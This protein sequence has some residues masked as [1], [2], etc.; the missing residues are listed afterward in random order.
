MPDR[1]KIHQPVKLQ[2]VQ[3]AR[4]RGKTAERGYGSRWQKLRNWWLRE[5][6]LCAHCEKQG[7][8]TTATQV[9]H[10]IPHNGDEALLHDV[11]NLQSLCVPCHNRKTKRGQ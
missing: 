1:P 5:H 10:I 2:R 9:D 7:R 4:P 3:I 8:M 11:T 6:P